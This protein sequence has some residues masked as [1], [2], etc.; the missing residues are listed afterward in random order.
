VNR[1]DDVV[2]VAG[3]AVVVA[4]VWAVLR[5]VV[6]EVTAAL[7]VTALVLA[8]VDTDSTVDEE[9]VVAG[10]LGPDAPGEPLLQATSP[11]VG[12][13]IMATVRRAARRTAPSL[14]APRPPTDRP[15]TDRPMIIA[16]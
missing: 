8:L 2:L 1:I 13:A 10:A 11:A 4:E 12:T 6:R 3:T 5:E 7:D 15:P 16:A 14:A 9:T